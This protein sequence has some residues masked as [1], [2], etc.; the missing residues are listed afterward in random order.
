V[1]ALPEPIILALLVAQKWH[2]TLT[3]NVAL[4]YGLNTADGYDGGVLPLSRWLRLTTLLVPSPR[5]DGVLLSRLEVLPS[6][7]LLDLLGVR[8]LITNGGTPGKADMQMVD[9]GDL[10][11]F[12]RTTVVPRSLVV[13]GATSAAD[14]SAALDRMANTDFDSNREVVVQTPASPGFSSAPV[15]VVPDKVGAERWHAHVSLIRPGYLLQREAWYPGWRARVDGVE[16]PIVRADL[17]F[18]AVALG[19]GEHDVE[20]FFDSASF[21]RGLL[22]SAGSLIVVIVLLTWRWLPIMR[23]RVQG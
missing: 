18:R 3:P 10:R 5:P 14:D 4:Q 11:L 15:T 23:V 17:L 1:G 21:N 9:F 22:L 13:F 2:D 8:Y 20:I 19:P 7:R 6:D 16:T 12:A